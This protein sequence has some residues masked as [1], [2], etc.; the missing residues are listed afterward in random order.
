MKGQGCRVKPMSRRLARG[1]VVTGKWNRR[2]YTIERLLGEGANGIVYLVRSRRRLYAMKMGFD[3][4]D[5]QSEVNA[6]K[7]LDKHI[8]PHDPFLL[9]VDDYRTRNGSIPF[10]VMKYIEGKRIHEFLRSKGREWV[11]PV[12]RNLLERLNEL[13]RHGFIFGDLKMENVMVRAYGEVEL[14]DYGGVTP[15]GQAVRQFT[16][17]YDR[18]YWGG[19]SRTADEQYDLFSFAALFLQLLYPDQHIKDPTTVLPQNRQP[20]L[21]LEPLKRDHLY[22]PLFPIFKKMLEGR[23]ATS[24][25]AL[26]AWREASMK[27]AQRGW[28]GASRTWVK[29]K[30]AMSP[31][32]G[33]WLIASA[34]GLVVTLYMLFQ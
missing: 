2:S 8:R 34:L 28:T 1:T 15:L 21:L 33:S 17:I 20:L 29:R 24:R 16:E 12:G 23:Y 5:H 27:A 18:G 9:D 11:Y 32:L 4:L 25:Q 7:T 22:A 6:L 14:V 13:H 31:W 10:Y 19:G 3:A 30:N 26:A